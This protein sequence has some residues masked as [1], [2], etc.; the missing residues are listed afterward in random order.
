MFL[1]QTMAAA[2]LVAATTPAFAHADTL[3]IPFIGVNFGGDAGKTFSSARESKQTAY[4]VSAAFF[5][6]GVVGIEGDFGY[7][8][9]FFGKS[10]AGGSSVTTIVGNLVL[11]IPFGGQKGFGIR[12]YFLAGAGVLKST[13]DF[14]S[15]FDEGSENSLAWNTGGGILMFFGNNYG[16]R[17]D[18]RYFKTFDDV[19]TGEGVVNGPGKVDFTRTTLGFVFRF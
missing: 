19:D 14:G 2:L 5:G 3:I 18:L 7:S 6:G 1:R 10:D 8:P 11:A 17:F 15:V 13:A 12:P 9:D 4:G 16:V